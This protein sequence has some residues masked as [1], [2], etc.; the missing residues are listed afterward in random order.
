MQR[1]TDDLINNWKHILPFDVAGK[2]CSN[3]S[4]EFTKVHL[5]QHCRHCGN[6]CCGSCLQ[7]MH[8]LNNAKKHVCNNCH[9]MLTKFPS[10]LCE[11]N[12]IIEKSSK[13]LEKV[14]LDYT[15]QDL[16]QKSLPIPP[17][18]FLIF[19]TGSRGD[20]QP[21][22]ALGM[23]MKKYGHKITIATHKCFRDFVIDHGL[24]FYPLPGDPKDLMDLMVSDI[25]LELVK[26]KF[27][28]HR[29]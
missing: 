2:Q 23:E 9:A 10:P 12:N 14:S 17:L 19:L 29:E 4:Y 8:F 18:H 13:I 28:K 16:T 20:V 25:N 22:V 21:F 5:P 7:E 6:A 26:D 1:E 15:S 24:Q 11:F 27:P 3:C